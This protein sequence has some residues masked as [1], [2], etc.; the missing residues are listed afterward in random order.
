MRT[1]LMRTIPLIGAA[2]LMSGCVTINVYFPEAAAN[3]AADKIVDDVLQMKPAGH[4]APAPAP[5][6]QEAPQ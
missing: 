4:A 5:A 1:C 6:S 2:V 3:Q